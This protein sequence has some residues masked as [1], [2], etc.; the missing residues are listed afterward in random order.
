MSGVRVIYS[1]RMGCSQA[2]ACVFF[3]IRTQ[4]FLLVFVVRWLSD[5]LILVWRR[6]SEQLSKAR[7]V[8][9][10]RRAIT[11]RL[12]PFWMFDAQRVVYLSLK[13]SVRADL[14][15]RFRK[16][17]CFHDLKRRRRLKRR[18][19]AYAGFSSDTSEVIRD[20]SFEVANQ[21]NERS[22]LKTK[23]RGSYRAAKAAR[24]RI[25]SGKA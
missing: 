6:E 3:C 9:F 16:S 2:P 15:R 22:R 7:F 25:H 19:F 4:H 23:A 5:R 18:H 11:I 12:N 21:S 24:S 20:P 17:L 8:R 13:L 10:T 14:L 1:Q